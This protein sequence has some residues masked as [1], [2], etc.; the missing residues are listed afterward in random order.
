MLLIRIYEQWRGISFL[1]DHFSVVVR[2]RKLCVIILVYLGSAFVDCVVM[3]WCVV[4]NLYLWYCVE[5]VI[6]F[7]EGTDALSEVTDLV[8]DIPQ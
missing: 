6:C 4:D 7:H 2:G 1:G 3:S 5:V 8:S